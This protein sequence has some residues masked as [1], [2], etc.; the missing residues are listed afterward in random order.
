M[1]LAFCILQLVINWAKRTS[2]AKIKG[3]K[4][5]TGDSLVVTDP[6]T[7]PAVVKLFFKVNGFHSY[8]MNPYPWDSGPWPLRKEHRPNGIAAARTFP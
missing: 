5:N 6:T 7:D 3:K 2:C 4:Y 8:G 1:S